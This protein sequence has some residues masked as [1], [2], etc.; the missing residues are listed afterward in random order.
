MAG[1]GAAF[2]SPDDRSLDETTRVSTHIA[3]GFNYRFGPRFALRLELRWLGT[4][5]G[6]GGEAIC[7][8]GCT[9]AFSTRVYSQVQGNFGLQFS[10]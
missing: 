9:V 10:F 4:F 5:V 3:G 8:G 1:L 6:S 7:S 2:I